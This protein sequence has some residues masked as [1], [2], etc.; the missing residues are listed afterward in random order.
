M[1]NY[2]TKRTTIRNF[3][4]KEVPNNIITDILTAAAQAPTTGG[5]QLYSVI[6]TRDETIKNELCLQHFNQ[7]A[8]KGANLLLTFCADFN[9]FE[10]WCILRNATPGYRNFQSFITALL[11]VTIFAQQ[12]NT[13]AEIN[14]LGCC[15]LGT[16]TYNAPKIAQILNLPE[17]VVPV[18]TL[19]VG[20]PKSNCC[21]QPTE[22]LPISSII[23]SEKYND[24]TDSDIENIYFEK[25]NLESNQKF[26]IENS[27]ETLAQ[28]FTDIRY[29]KNNNEIFSKLYYDFIECSGFKLT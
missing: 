21:T 7:P 20:Y 24:Y 4:D 23:H 28:V 12:F 6:V 16:T 19:A 15:Y 22:R 8:S 25:E 13:I 10:K 18:I 2:F 17:M 11:D 9:R 5:M 27:K 26:V 1:D 14:G 3:S 29:T